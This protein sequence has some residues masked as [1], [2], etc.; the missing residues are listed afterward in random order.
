MG[1]V[2]H[3]ILPPGLRL[4]YDLGLKT[5]QLDVMVP[6][7]MPSLLS[8]LTGNIVGLKQPGILTPSASFEAE[9]GM[10]GLAEIPLKSEAPGPS[11]KADL[12][13]PMPASKEEA[14]VDLV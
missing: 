3:D 11:H 6:V 10:G 1:P 14:E 4:D 8:G 9:A 12:I 2:A 5:R 7:L 13:P